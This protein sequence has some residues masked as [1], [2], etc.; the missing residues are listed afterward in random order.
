[1]LDDLAKQYAQHLKRRGFAM[2]SQDTY[3]R[4]L[5]HFLA[6]L[7]AR[8]LDGAQ[9]ISRDT[10]V[11]Y[12][13][14][15]YTEPSQ[16]GRPFALR[17]QALHLL[18]VRSFLKFLVREGVLLLSPADSVEMPRHPPRHA[19]RNVPTE[20]EV[21]RLL[22]TPDPRTRL[23]LR[24][25]AMFEVLYSTGM[26]VGELLAL[27]VYDVDLATG[28]VQIIAG[29]GSKNRSV[30]LGRM[31][32]RALR[33]YLEK[34][35]PHYVRGRTTNL[36]F[37][38]THGRRLYRNIVGR[39]LDINVRKAGIERKIT[40]HSLR[41]ACATHM[42]RGRAS[43]RHIQELLGHKLLSTTQLYTHVQIEDLKAVHAR[44]HP[45]ERRARANRNK[46]TSPP[47]ES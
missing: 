24:D 25:R 41:H 43:V 17:T 47:D 10:V 4:G 38:S 21:A 11:A 8:Q 3:A 32:V 19:P 1:M 29:K 14:A 46:S 36:L 16:S 27:K 37:V 13:T 35:R 45:R 26:R 34:T 39:Q 12:Q 33:V 44:T 22:T 5:A 42:L 30:P 28:L 20:E 2:R 7:E 23:G 6:F 9:E 18:V 31:A 15:L 40:A